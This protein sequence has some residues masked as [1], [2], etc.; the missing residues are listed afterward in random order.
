M[1]TDNLRDFP[2]VSLPAGTVGLSPA[3][4]AAA[5]VGTDPARGA[6][7]VRSVAARSGQHGPS[8]APGE[9]LDLL[10]RR[11]AVDEA[12]HLVRPHL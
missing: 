11:C 3:R 10:A 2:A 5:V 9:F 4:F 1:V 12:V 8:P 6:G 7:A